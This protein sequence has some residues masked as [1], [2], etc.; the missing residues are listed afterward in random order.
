MVPNSIDDLSRPSPS[1]ASVTRTLAISSLRRAASARDPS[2]S[3]NSTDS[4]NSNATPTSTTTID[5]LSPN[6]NCSSSDRRISSDDRPLNSNQAKVSLE[7][8]ASLLAR[9]MAMAKLTGEAPPAPPANF[10]SATPLF[11]GSGAPLPTLEALRERAALRKALG[12]GPGA[13]R[14][15][16]TVTG[17]GSN[18][19]GNDLMGRK[20][21]VKSIGDERAEAR[22][23]LM[24]KLSSRRLESPAPSNSMRPEDMPKALEVVGRRGRARPRSSSLPLD[25]I[26]AGSDPEGSPLN[27]TS[28][29]FEGKRSSKSITPTTTTTTEPTF[30][31]TSPTPQANSFHPQFNSSESSIPITER[32]L[33]NWEH[34]RPSSANSDLRPPMAFGPRNL[35]I[36][37]RT[38]E[39]SSVNSQSSSIDQ[40]P[41]VLRRGSL[42]NRGY[43]DSLFSNG[44]T[45]PTSISSFSSL[46]PTHIQNLSFIP[47]P[48]KGLNITRRP[49]MAT[50]GIAAVEEALSEQRRGSSAS[51]SLTSQSD[52]VGY[53]RALA[54]GIR[55]GGSGLQ[56]STLGLHTGLGGSTLSLGLPS[57]SLASASATESQ[58]FS[59]SPTTVESPVIPPAAKLER[60]ERKRES[61]L[62][63]SRDGAFPPPEE[64]YQFP[65]PQKDVSSYNSLLYYHL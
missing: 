13:L 65:G 17:V 12:E 28:S 34:Y 20:V 47:V 23:N 4:I 60:I 24:R 62:T 50:F 6:N 57:P 36:S 38:S 52:I 58:M 16:N 40:I 59:F 18:G 29:R 46:D 48:T 1:S 33:S 5:F 25:W 11:A 30:I 44:L 53:H 7:R 26:R 27:D 22:V 19:T 63:R 2:T 10:Y 31:T 37:S 35:S 14:R 49:S 39:F 32:N 9:S 45:F 43:S 51:S 21:S 56:T 15:N 54:S 64:G 61:G 8:T 55:V 41:V 42:L 3:I